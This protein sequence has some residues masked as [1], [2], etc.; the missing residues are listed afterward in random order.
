MKRKVI[1]IANS[2]QLVSLPRKWS[3]KYNIQK[4]DELEVEEDGNKIIISTEKDLS[5][6]K[7][8]IDF[9]G[10]S[11][12]I[13]R[14]LS[15]LYR[16][17]Y[18][19]IRIMFEKSSELEVVQSTINQE[20]IGFE[21]VEEGKDYIVVKQVT[22]IDQSEFQSMLRR[23][24]IFL[25]NTSDECLEALKSNNI[26]ALRNLVL[27]DITINK[28]TNYC[29]RAINKKEG[30]F[31]HIGPGYA[32]VEILEKISDNYRDLCK[33]V[34]QNKVKV[35]KQMI[36]ALSE[37]NSLM[38]DS[39]KL[40][41]NFELNG[42]ESFLIKKDRVSETIMNLD[43]KRGEVGMLLYLNIIADNIFYLNG[44]IIINGL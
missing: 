4:G 32:I 9:K 44:P 13:H 19:E 2:T 37:I 41:Y 15:S 16:A 23:V 29:R 38:R 35:N 11:L 8:E 31:K 5:S 28:L 25:I 30:Y 7:S 42:M 39:Y 21:I 3:Q 18:N 34:S 14:A 26:N 17:G 20:L 12:L 6:S 1:Q 40:S 33:Y 22:S 43:A 24:F 27:R 10:K 36:D